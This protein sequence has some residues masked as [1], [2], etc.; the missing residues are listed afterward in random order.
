ME[1]TKALYAHRKE[2]FGKWVCSIFADVF[3]DFSECR[4][5]GLQVVVNIRWKCL[6]AI[7]ALHGCAHLEFL[8]PQL[9]RTFALFAQKFNF[10][11]HCTTP[12]H[13]EFYHGMK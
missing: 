4:N 10:E 13:H 3:R 9:T 7:R 12:F 11:V 1:S 5:P 8:W 6:T 2:I